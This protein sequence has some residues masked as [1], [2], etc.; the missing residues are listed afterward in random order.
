MDVND[1]KMNDLPDVNVP[2]SVDVG[3]DSR[4]NISNNSEIIVGPE[5]N[6]KPPEL[7][8]ETLPDLKYET[9]IEELKDDLGGIQYQNDSAESLAQ[10]QTID[11]VSG[12]I[13][14]VIDNQANL[15]EDLEK[16]EVKEPMQNMD[17]VAV[18]SQ[19]Q[20]KDSIINH[21]D[22]VRDLEKIT[23]SP[24]NGAMWTV[25][26][27]IEE[28]VKD[29]LMTQE[30]FDLV[31]NKHIETGKDALDIA[32]EANYVTLSNI[33]RVQAKLSGIE[34]VDLGNTP[35]VPE[36]LSFLQQSLAEKFRV[37]PLNIDAKNNILLVA[38]SDPLN[39]DTIQFIEK[40]TQ[41]KLDIK[42]ADE[43]EI[44]AAIKLRYTAGLN[45]DVNA[46][47]NDKEMNRQKSVVGDKKV[48][49]EDPIPKI[50]SKILADAVNTR[51][52]D[53]HI[54]PLETKTR[55]RFRID[56]ILTEKLV[57]PSMVH[58]ALVSR[59]K[60][61]SDLK[62]DERRLPQDGRFNYRDELTDVDLRVST[63]P[64][65]YGEK[66]VMRL[67]KKNN[68]VATFADLGLRGRA[69][70]NLE[71]AILHPHGIILVTGPTGSGKTTTLYSVLTKLNSPKVNIMTLE[72]P[73]EYQMVGINQVQ[74][75]SQIGLT[76]ANGLR[77]FLRQ[78]PNIIMVG[79]IRDS[80]TA[81]LAIQASLTGHLVL[82][83]LH[84]NSASGSLPR[85]L[86][87]GAETFLL[88]SSMIAVLAQRVV[89]KVCTTCKIEQEIDIHQVESLKKV[90][91]SLYP[92][93]GVSKVVKGQGCSE[94]NM[95]GYLGRVAI[96][97]VLPITEKIAKMILERKTAK[98]I[99]DQA[100]ME[101]MI[102]MKQDGYLKVIEGITTIEEV[103][104]VADT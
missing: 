47:L 27:V 34:L 14:G 74:I 88:A 55:V 77:S 63:L 75:N 42:W 28:L 99:E 26:T 68:E 73:V 9:K 62:I 38:M 103:L 4:T 2:W 90:L 83:T 69:L 98:E 7:I 49:R 1:K 36:S 29:G 48:I 11:S 31:Q 39:L 44:M 86:D 52:S 16:N 54:E 59:V 80:E 71:D 96:Y 18:D 81:E 57:L 82:S 35:I 19:L 72:D 104:R 46:V 41:C 56:G 85:L 66:I 40:K 94:C 12:N 23:V 53:I 13:D 5:D 58:D 67:L 87:M 61:L 79:E 78:D 33:K 20:N 32:I 45:K 70:K 65:V 92:K 15:N 22:Q 93:D 102:T 51:A 6:S 95:T 101:G 89:R 10:V 84:T 8:V 50:V 76:F 100:V 30:Q 43:S 37:L 91:G 3:E 97:E 21:Q 17:Q 60:I 24:T 25:W 64:T